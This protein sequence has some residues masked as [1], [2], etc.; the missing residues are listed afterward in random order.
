MATYRA[1]FCQFQP[2][3]VKGFRMEPT[4]KP[5]WQTEDGSVRLYRGDA[6]EVLQ[7]LPKGSID[8]VVTD[9][10]YSSGGAFRGD[11]MNS[12]RNKYQSSDV[13]SELPTF[14]GDNRDQHGWLTWC[15]LWLIHS[16]DIVRPGGMLCM[17]TDWRQLPTATDAV[18]CGGWVWRGLVV[19]D[20]VNARPMPSRFTA[21]C[22]YVVW[23][24]NGP[25][26][27]DFATGSYHS[28]VVRVMP[29]A[30][31]DREHSTQKPVEVME[32]LVAVAGDGQVV[33]DPFMGSGTTGVACIRTG[34]H[35]I[36]IEKEKHYFDVAVSRIEAELNRAPLFEPPP[37]IQRAMFSEDVA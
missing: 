27:F 12:T 37:A 8:A 2:G 9:P 20:K 10:P 16:A 7:S 25:R 35:F 17:F 6:L 34:R 26:D 1:D 4:I 28:G 5:D 11:R 13:I 33:L 29:P 23:A 36:G 30:T 24:T 15:S 18:Q 14:T 31:E 22:E 32:H 3:L 21:Q 19:W